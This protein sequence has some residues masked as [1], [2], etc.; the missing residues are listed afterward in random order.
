MRSINDK[1]GIST[2]ALALIVAAIV[3]VASVA[4]YFIFIYDSGD[5]SDDSADSSDDPADSPDDQIVSSV[6]EYATYT[7]LGA[8][9]GT[10]FDGKLKI[11]IVDE[12]SSQY[13]IETSYLLYSTTA[14]IRTAF[15]IDSER[16]WVDIDQYESP[17]VKTGSETMSTKWGERNV[18]IYTKVVDGETRMMYVGVSDGVIYGI[19]MEVDSVL[20]LFML[21]DTNTIEGDPGEGVGDY[22]I[23]SVSGSSGA[24]ALDG[25]LYLIIIDQSPT[26]YKIQFAS[27][28]YQTV[29]G[30]RTFLFSE[31]YSDWVDIDEHESY[32]VKTGTDTISTSWGTRDVDIYTQVI[33]G[34]TTVTYLG[35]S[36][37]VP[38][39]ITVINGGETMTFTLVGASV[40]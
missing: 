33:E 2:I 22:E 4:S 32:G 3:G 8:T 38:Y 5:P 37:G 9:T 39:K 17:G 14:G 7:V 31:N 6:G 35:R 27:V 13:Q 34:E 36:D 28:I 25:I 10:L 12:S 29:S 40:L 19:S 1:K 30:V 15:F 23:Y 26:E 21:I 20:M 11:E 24:T 16:E 18:D